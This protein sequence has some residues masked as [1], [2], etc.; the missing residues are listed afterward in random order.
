MRFTRLMIV[1][2]AV[3][4]AVGAAAVTKSRTCAGRQAQGH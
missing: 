3:T 2:V 4:I 1:S